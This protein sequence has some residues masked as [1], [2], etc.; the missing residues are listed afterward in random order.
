VYTCVHVCL[1]VYVSVCIS[2]CLHVYVC[3]CVYVS[4]SLCC[5]CLCVCSCA[6][7]RVRVCVPVEDVESFHHFSPPQLLRHGLTLTLQHAVLAVLAG[8]GACRTHLS[9]SLRSQVCGHAQLSHGYISTCLC[10]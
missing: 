2:V 1:C 9:P 10:I 6:C 4:V 3:V 7:L 8:R 5:M